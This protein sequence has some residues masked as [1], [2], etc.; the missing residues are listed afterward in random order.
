VPAHK[1]AMAVVNKGIHQG[2]FSFKGAVNDAR[3]TV[4]DLAALA[5]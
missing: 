1:V 3:R 4:A 2:V 5:K